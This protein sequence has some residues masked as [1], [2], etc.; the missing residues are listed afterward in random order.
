M[1]GYKFAYLMF[2]HVKVLYSAYK[3]SRVFLSA[4]QVLKSS[5]WISSPKKDTK[6]T[7]INL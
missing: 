7:K 6:E 1:I 3:I 4:Y 2:L 5:N